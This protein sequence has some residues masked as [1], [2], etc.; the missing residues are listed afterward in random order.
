MTSILDYVSRKYLG[1][2]SHRVFP[3]LGRI[4]EIDKIGVN[5][6]MKRVEDGISTGDN[7]GGPVQLSALTFGV[8]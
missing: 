5:Q 4:E 3:A 8:S 2:H 6:K 7:T 1:T